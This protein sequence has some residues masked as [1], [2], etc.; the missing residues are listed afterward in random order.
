MK[1]IDN[2]SL[3]ELFDL[4][5]EPPEDDTPEDDPSVYDSSDDI[6]YV[7]KQ[8]KQL[9]VT[10]NEILKSAQAMIVAAPDAETISSASNMIASIGHLVSEFNKSVLMEKNFKS[11]VDLMDMKHE[12]D[13]EKERIKIEARKEI[14]GMRATTPQLGSGNTFI[15]NNSKVVAFSQE[16]IIKQ[17]VSIEEHKEEQEATSTEN[18]DIIETDIDV[19]NEEN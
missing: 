7:D 13:L 17:L 19:P 6:T 15:Q 14:A 2:D 16:D 1:A 5:I 11:K 8:L 3:S 9:M 12:K 18:E 4:E 10:S